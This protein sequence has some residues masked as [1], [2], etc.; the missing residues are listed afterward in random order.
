MLRQ[1]FS[2]YNLTCVQHTIMNFMGASDVYTISRLQIMAYQAASIR[3][4]EEFYSESYHQQL[5][6]WLHPSPLMMNRTNSKDVGAPESNIFSLDSLTIIFLSFGIN[7]GREWCFS[8][9]ASISTATF[10]SDNHEIKIS[11]SMEMLHVGFCMAS[12]RNV[13]SR[14]CQNSICAG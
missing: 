11:G 3:R 6:D 2:S 8:L 12:I 10:K 5:A 4:I 14:W 7:T 13:V 9:S 1:E